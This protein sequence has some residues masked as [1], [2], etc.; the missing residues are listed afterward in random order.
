LVDMERMFSNTQKFNQNLSKW[1]TSSVRY[2]NNYDRDAIVWQE[3]Y[4]PNFSMPSE[5]KEGS[6]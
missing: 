4:K 2:Y 6:T 3:N 1:N 5:V